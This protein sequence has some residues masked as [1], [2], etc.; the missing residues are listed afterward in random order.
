VVTTYHPSYVLR[1]PGEDAKHEAFSI[2]VQGLKL[3]QALL[4]RPLDEPPASGHP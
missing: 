3:A 1:V 2:M 4:D